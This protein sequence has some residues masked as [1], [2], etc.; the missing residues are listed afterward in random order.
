MAAQ[1]QINADL[2]AKKTPPIIRIARNE[3]KKENSPQITQNEKLYRGCYVEPEGDLLCSE[4]KLRISHRPTQTHTDIYP[5][6]F[7]GQK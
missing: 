5:A 4:F 2:R 6:D 7:A 1:A 3:E